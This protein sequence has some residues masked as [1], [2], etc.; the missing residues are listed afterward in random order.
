M[1]IQEVVE[2]FAE[3][4]AC[5]DISWIKGVLSYNIKQSNQVKTQQNNQVEEVKS[6]RIEMPIE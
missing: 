1:T 3:K 5:Q 4:G 2:K 6:D